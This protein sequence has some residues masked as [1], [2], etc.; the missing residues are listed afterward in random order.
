MEKEN[1]LISSCLFG[2][3]V[4]YDGKH[5]CLDSKFL[6]NLKKR[7]NLFSFCPEVQGGL[8]IPRSPCE[9]ISTSTL[10]IINKKNE[11]QT[12]AFVLGASKALDL[13]KKEN[14][15]KA[16]LKS[17]SP[18]CSSKLIYDGT[19]TNKKIKGIGVTTR[20]LKENGIVVLDENDTIKL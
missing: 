2:E 11:N 6:E 10:K 18:S 17:N 9:I 19:F 7:Y 4:R 15:T 20:L 14:I 1:L 8:P 3:D 16:L 12:K 5:N 13:C